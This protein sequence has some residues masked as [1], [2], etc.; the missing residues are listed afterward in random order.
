MTAALQD[1]S[2]LMG[3][4]GMC[5]VKKVEKVAGQL[6]WAGGLFGWISKCGGRGWGNGKGEGDVG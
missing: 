3:Q 1:V 5:D 4:K 2:Q 6:S